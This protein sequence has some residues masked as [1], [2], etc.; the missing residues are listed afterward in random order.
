MVERLLVVH[1]SGTKDFLGNASYA[2]RTALSRIVVVGYLRGT[3]R[4][5]RSR[6]TGDPLATPP[7]VPLLRASI[8]ATTRRKF[9]V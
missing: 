8:G 2:L 3:D 7:S 9:L 6:T 5:A 4:C 1:E